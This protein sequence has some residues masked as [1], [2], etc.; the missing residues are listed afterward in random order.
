MSVE[1]KPKTT[2]PHRLQINGRGE[3]IITGVTDVLSFDAKEVLL[4]TVQGMLM[5][6]G[7]ELHVS[8]L[9]LEKGEVNI[10]GTVNSATYSDS[11]AVKSAG[12]F[13]GR[14]FR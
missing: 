1:D 3:T 12:S 2:G 6:C 11:Q 7:S 10:D 4:E 9:T 5:I 8:R 14:L 13:I